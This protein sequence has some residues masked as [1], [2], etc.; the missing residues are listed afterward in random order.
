MLNSSSEGVD[1]TREGVIVFTDI[2]VAEAKENATLDNGPKYVQTLAG[3]GNMFFVTP[4]GTDA[5]AQS[6]ALSLVGGDTFPN[7]LSTASTFECI[8]CVHG[9][10]VPVHQGTMMDSLRRVAYNQ[11]CTVTFNPYQLY[12][13]PQQVLTFVFENLELRSPESFISLYDIRNEI[14]LGTFHGPMTFPNLTIRALAPTRITFVY[15]PSWRGL[16]PPSESEDKY[17]TM[18]YK[19]RWTTS[20]GVPTDFEKRIWGHKDCIDRCPLAGKDACYQRC[21]LSRRRSSEQVNG[22]DGKQLRRSKQVDGNDAQTPVPSSPASDV[23]TDIVASSD[24]SDGRRWDV[25]RKPHEKDGGEPRGRDQVRANNGAKTMMEEGVRQ[26]AIAASA[27]LGVHET[28]DFVQKPETLMLTMNR[29]D[30]EMLLPVKGSW[31]GTCRSSTLCPADAACEPADLGSKPYVSGR[32][33]VALYVNGSTFIRHVW[34]C[35]HTPWREGMAT[36]VLLRVNRDKYVI[37]MQTNGVTLAYTEFQLV[38]TQSSADQ[39]A[40]ELRWAAYSFG[41]AMPAQTDTISPGTSMQLL[42]SPAY[43]PAK[44]K[45]TVG[46]LDGIMVSVVDDCSLWDL[47]PTA[48]G[49][50]PQLEKDAIASSTTHIL[51]YMECNNSV[52]AVHHLQKEDAECAG[53]VQAFLHRDFTAPVPASMAYACQSQC[54]KRFKVAVDEAVS[55]CASGMREIEMPKHEI[56]WRRMLKKLVMVASAKYYVSVACYSNHLGLSCLSVHP[57]NVVTAQDCTA[58][59]A[60]ANTLQAPSFVAASPNQCSGRCLNQLNVYVFQGGCCV[61]TVEEASQQ[62][63]RDLG[64]GQPLDM[65]PGDR[66]DPFETKMD[67]FKN[68]IRFLPPARCPGAEGSGITTDCMLTSCGRLNWPPSKCCDITCERGSCVCGSCHVQ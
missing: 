8:S 38:W 62:F 28:C 3:V 35:P 44:P 51:L 68:L 6:H 5:T 4:N 1:T 34:G 11:S 24:G 16:A 49:L 7:V 58:I 12:A 61:R 43:D 41:A 59:S 46:S 25:H 2:I 52:A 66:A 10:S 26:L 67:S 33:N 56:L 60:K 31:Q 22:E 14:H 53:L 18:L 27:Q 50:F 37:S 57:H 63:W 40:D 19:F 29:V 47:R 9:L 17:V 30:G 13:G 42:F 15:G 23:Q 21:L 39:M 55:T 64:L 48:T 36:G 65:D 54:M 32:C 45:P 20:R